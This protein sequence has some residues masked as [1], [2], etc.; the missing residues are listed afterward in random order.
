MLGPVP[1]KPQPAV[2]TKEQEAQLAKER[3]VKFKKWLQNKAIK[4]K[5]FEV[6]RFFAGMV[7]YIL[8]LI[9]TCILSI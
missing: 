5:A 8:F 9:L 7:H 4:D 1:T 3:D 2:H 6:R